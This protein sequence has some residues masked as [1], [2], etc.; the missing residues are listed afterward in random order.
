MERILESEQDVQDVAVELL[1]RLSGSTAQ[2]ATV[3]ALKGDLGAGKTTFTKAL[4]SVL[5][6]AE[7]V[8]SPTFVIQKSY[9]TTHPQYSALIH[10]DA[11]RLEGA[12]DAGAL[13]LGETLRDPRNLVVVEWP[14][15]IGGALPGDA[16]TLRF[17]HVSE[18]VRRVTM[19]A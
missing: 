17:E 7:H 5:G 6:I 14:E 4:A 9:A 12:A 8:T 10:I 15:R 3:L 11:Y 2:S 19:P 18:R 1:G 13:K 16:I